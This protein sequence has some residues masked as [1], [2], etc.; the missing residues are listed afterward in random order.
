MNREN[1]ISF[2]L[3]TMMFQKTDLRKF[4]YRLKTHPFEIKQRRLL[5]CYASYKKNK[6]DSTIEELKSF[7]CSD[8]FFES[9]RLYL[10]GLAYNQY[11]VFVQSQDYLERSIEMLESINENDFIFFPYSVLVINLGN[12]RKLK[13]M[14]VNLDGLKR[15]PV[16]DL[17][18]T[19]LRYQCEVCYC[20]VTEQIEAGI[21]LIKYVLGKYQNEIGEFKTFFLTL[22]FMLTFKKDDYD[23]CY[24]ILNKYKDIKSFKVRANYKYMKT[25]LDNI[26]YDSPLY[27]YKQDYQDNLDLL[28]QLEVIKH[29]SLGEIEQAKK[30]WDQLSLLAPDIYSEDFEYR[31]DYCLFSVA[32]N[33]YRGHNIDFGFDQDKIASLSGPMEKLIYILQGANRPISKEE[34][35]DLIWSEE[36]SELAG[37]RLSK[38]VSRM[39]KTT[40]YQVKLSKG[41]YSISSKK[42][43]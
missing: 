32:V 28:Q 37:K 26:A 30:Y 15:V 13:L 7:I 38:L 12:Q 41:V 17:N 22:Q 5:K 1:E 31:G 2:F 25:L 34:L 29:L 39:K 24:N 6:L 9:V 14:K 35:V 23:E 21:D 10:I 43:A 11:G 19:L 40:D 27:I 4:K 33:K 3:E 42:S 18:K 16:L 8:L 36:F 20:V